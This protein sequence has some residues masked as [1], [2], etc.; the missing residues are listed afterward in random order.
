MEVS[1][2]RIFLATLFISIAATASMCATYR[3]TAQDRER[4]VLDVRW[5]EIKV[6]EKTEFD[7]W[8]AEATAKHEKQW[9]ES[10]LKKRL[11]ERRAALANAL[12][13]RRAKAEAV[14][15]QRDDLLPAEWELTE[16]ELELSA[17][18]AD[19]IVILKKFHEKA[20]TAEEQAK[21]R[22]DAGKI[23]VDAAE[24]SET[25]A[26][27]LK[28]EIAL[29]REFDRGKLSADEVAVMAAKERAVWQTFRKVRALFEAGAKGGEHEKHAGA[30]REFLLARSRLALAQGRRDA[31]LADLKLGCWFGKRCVEAIQA[32]YDVGTVSLDSLLEA[33]RGHEEVQL[34][35]LRAYRVY[36]DT[37]KPVGL[38]DEPLAHG[39]NELKQAAR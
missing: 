25:K 24:L 35:F 29:E 23:G 33:Q 10:V 11:E 5:A 27:R 34:E 38:P 12:S 22:V 3:A 16:A 19:R 28:A 32:A 14:V 30:A 39:D 18:N 6:W 26:L 13:A 20:R 9:S 7:R 21:A 37:K 8:L 2:R 15:G 31:A 4:T 36:G 1:M 17:R